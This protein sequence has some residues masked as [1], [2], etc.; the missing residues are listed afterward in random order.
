MNRLTTRSVAILATLTLG[1]NFGLAHADSSSRVSTHGLDLRDPNGV[2]KLYARIQQSARNV[3]E[4]AA[5]PWM[6]GRVA[7]VEKCIAGSVDA[8]VAQARITGLTAL[9]QSRKAG[10]SSI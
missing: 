7:Y 5:S 4:Q 10:T 8:A 9:H 6:S 3:C 2:A 1:F